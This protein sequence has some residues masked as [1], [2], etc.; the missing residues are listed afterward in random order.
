MSK[1]CKSIHAKHSAAMQSAGCQHRQ[2]I[3]DGNILLYYR[4]FYRASICAALSIYILYIHIIRINELF[5]KS[6]LLQMA[7]TALLKHLATGLLKT[8]MF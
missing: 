7:H 5:L 1:N 6:D 2:F 4:Y 3:P 8:E